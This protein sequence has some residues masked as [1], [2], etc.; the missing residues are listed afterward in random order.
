[1]EDILHHLEADR[2]DIIRGQGSL[3]LDHQDRSSHSHNLNIYRNKSVK[4]GDLILL[5]TVSILGH[6]LSKRNT[7]RGLQHHD[8]IQA[9][10][11][12]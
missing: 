11:Q 5:R 9:K 10:L 1:M 3:L 4:T 8:T 7:H 12:L 2:M 6:L